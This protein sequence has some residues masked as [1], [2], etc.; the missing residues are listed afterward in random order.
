MVHKTAMGLLSGDAL[1]PVAVVVAVF[2]LLVDLM[3]RRQRWAARYPPGPVPVPGLGNL[4][5]VDFYNMLVCCQKVKE[6]ASPSS[7]GGRHTH[8]HSRTH[9]H[10]PVVAGGEATECTG[11]CGCKQQQAEGCPR[12]D[13]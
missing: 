4:L 11:R 2:V 6:L 9:A 8:T 3:H 1:L 7:N 13:T 12:E 10:T 5:Q